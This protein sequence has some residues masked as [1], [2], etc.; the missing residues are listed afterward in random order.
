VTDVQARMAAYCEGRR[1]RLMRWHRLRY[2]GIKYGVI[3]P[4]RAPFPDMYWLHKIGRGHADIRHLDVVHRPRG[5]TGPDYVGHAEYQICHDCRVGKVWK[6][7]TVE[8]WQMR[9]IA[10]AMLERAQLDAPLYRWCTSGQYRHARPFWTKIA[11][12]TGLGYQPGNGCEHL[13][14]TGYPGH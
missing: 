6:I 11:E 9:G 14:R 5:S 4:E 1:L 2:L 8:E 13:E 7:Y 10:A 12:R 3:E